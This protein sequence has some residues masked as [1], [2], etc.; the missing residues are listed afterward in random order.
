MTQET[1]KPQLHEV[2]PHGKGAAL[3]G[4]SASHA[5][6]S[7]SL[8]VRIDGNTEL[9]LQWIM[10]WYQGNGVKPSKSVVIRR[11][12]KSLLDNIEAKM[13]APDLVEGETIVVK[14]FATN[15]PAPIKHLEKYLT[16]PLRPFS[17]IVTEYRKNSAWAAM[18]A[19][20]NK[21]HK[22]HRNK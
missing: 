18:N 21:R 8:T 3:Q 20:A 10:A 2:E 19:V 14:S 13:A 4:T 22:T 5:G 9:I 1:T 16:F 12:V 17:V 11:A 15:A 6:N 7:K